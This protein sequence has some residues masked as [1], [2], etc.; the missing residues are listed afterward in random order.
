MI[1]VLI[2]DD[3]IVA[4]KELTAQLSKDSGI[5][6]V[7]A[8]PDPFVA[9][10]MIVKLKP[11]V[12]TLDI[13]M[14]KMDG[15][16]FLKKLMKHFPMPVIVISSVAEKG[17]KNA[18][19]AL[20]L[21]A[22]DVMSKPSGTS[23]NSDETDTLIR[24]IKGAAKATPAKLQSTRNRPVR[25]LKKSSSFSPGKIIAIGASTG[26]TKA[27]EA[28]LRSFPVNSPPVVIVQHM[29]TNFT[30]A[31]ANSLNRVCTIMVRE[32]REGDILRPG[33]ALL[34]PG[35]SHM[36][37][38]SVNNQPVV[39]LH[40]GPQVHYQRPAV[41]VTFASLAAN[42][43]RNAIGIILTGMGSDG[44]EGLLAMRRLGSPTIAQDEAT[45][46]VF[47]MPKAAIDIGAAE[48]VWPL[49]DIAG[50]AL[51][52]ASSTRRAA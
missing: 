36:V 12:L 29:P 45:S 21:G 46:I 18:M 22:V 15:L 40:Q 33:V 32:G 44:A 38:K 26:G 39:T 10:S 52:F 6:I 17:S 30:A 14:P 13:E 4:R 50:H 47:G 27:I 28:V 16:T 31:F 3:S 48:A 9:R 2:V 1:K 19:E 24:M 41:D 42:V 8:A 25:P 11:D 7:G 43:G 51:D 35:G 37:F 20:R 49:F 5:K 23:I 34:A